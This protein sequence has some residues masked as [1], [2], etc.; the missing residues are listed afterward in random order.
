MSDDSKVGWTAVQT[1]EVFLAVSRM[2]EKPFV[3]ADKV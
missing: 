2:G 3:L 1:P